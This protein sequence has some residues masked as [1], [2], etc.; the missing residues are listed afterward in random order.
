MRI[1]TIYYL[2]LYAILSIFWSTTVRSQNISFF[3]DYLKN[4]EIFDAGQLKQI[5]HLPLKSF[6]A[7]NNMLAYEDNSGNFKI[8][9][10]H[11]LHQISS[12]ASSYKISDNLAALRMN[13]QLKVFDEGDVKSLTLNLTEYFLGDDI[14]VWFDDYEKRLKA[15]YNKEIYDLDD[16]LATGTMNGVTIGEN[17]VAF[18]DSQGYLN[19]FYDGNIE[20]ICFGERIKSISAGRDIVVFVE[21]PVNNFQAYYFGDLID[22]E[23]FEPVSFKTGDQFVAYVDANNYLKVFYDFKTETV[24]FDVPDFYETTDGL[25]VF[26]VQ[27]YFKIWHNGTIYTLESYIPQDYKMNNNVLAYIDQSGN[28]KFFNG[29]SVETISYEK[30]TDFEIHGDIVKYSFG[31]NSEHIYSQNKT[32][33]NN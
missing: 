20:R 9:H 5:E 4:V 24:S 14:L 2:C 11:F 16:A 13:T 15:Y 27:N 21:E 30:V 3:N 22:L 33:K 17:I 10:N 6:V 29:E 7:S 25:M 26:G 19:I 32:Y 28:L 12:F 23:G 1:K 8:Y 31:V 18:V